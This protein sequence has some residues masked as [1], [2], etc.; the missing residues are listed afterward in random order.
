M[1][2]EEAGSGPQ[3]LWDLPGPT[4]GGCRLCLAGLIEG[5]CPLT[6]E[7]GASSLGLLG[8]R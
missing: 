3:S 6:S 4:T 8:M 1:K 2:G 5:R 7:I